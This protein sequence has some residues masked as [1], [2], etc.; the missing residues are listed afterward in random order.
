[1]KTVRFDPPLSIQIL[2]RSH[3]PI[4]GEFYVKWV[5]GATVYVGAAGLF[6][7]GLYSGASQQG[8]EYRIDKVDLA[9]VQ[10]KFREAL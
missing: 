5:E 1:M 2:D 8:L 9:E 7:F 10:L 6:K 3:K 4:Q